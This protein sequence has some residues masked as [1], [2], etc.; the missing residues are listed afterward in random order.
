M[1]KLILRILGIACVLAGVTHAVL[2]VGGDWIIGVTP[3]SPIEPSL[4]SQNRFYGAAFM[5]YGFLLWICSKDVPRF[6]PISRILFATM[7]LAGL[8][9]WLAVMAHGWPT[10]QIMFLWA[11]ELFVPPIM[12][13]WLRH[14]LAK[15]VTVE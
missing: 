13:I 6:A 1:F 14:E 7:F 2:G 15:S 12:W 11:S 10:L 4:D 8:A 9:R 5:A 3:A